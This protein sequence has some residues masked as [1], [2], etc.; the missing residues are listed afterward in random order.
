MA[1]AATY[2]ARCCFFLLVGSLLQ[3]HR[4]W[5]CIPASWAGI[6]DGNAG[7]GKRLLCG[8]AGPDTRASCLCAGTRHEC[9][10]CGRF[11]MTP[12]PRHCRG[13][14]KVLC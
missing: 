3:R 2:H 12:G 14:D 13:L 9:E 5:Q 4:D 11:R 1:E 7:F 10:N 6:A 8:N